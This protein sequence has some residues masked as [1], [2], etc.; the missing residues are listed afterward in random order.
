M[1]F[2]KALRRRQLPTKPLGHAEPDS[3][4]NTGNPLMDTSRKRGEGGI[5]EIQSPQWPAEIILE[6]SWKAVRLTTQGPFVQ[7]VVPDFSFAPVR[8]YDFE[9]TKAQ[10]LAHGAC[11]GFEL[12]L[13]RP[14][15]IGLEPLALDAKSGEVLWRHSFL[16]QAVGPSLV[17]RRQPLGTGD[18]L[19]TPPK[20]PE[21]ANINV[22]G[23]FAYG[24]F[25]KSGTRLQDCEQLFAH[26][27]QSGDCTQIDLK[28][29]SELLKKKVAP[30]DGGRMGRAHVMYL[31]EFA[32]R[33]TWS[34]MQ[35]IA[36]GCIQVS[37]TCEGQTQSYQSVHVVE[38]NPAM[39]QFTVRFIPKT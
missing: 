5:V 2:E 9:A 35:A 29:Y 28:R 20:K 33:Q 17:L 30:P 18:W 7:S 26:I 31:D 12:I 34:V 25:A 23:L 11:A 19:V 13:Q 14:V 6:L 3:P 32:P 39:D 1:Q 22:L 27:T 21:L 10:H 36:F 24:G 4:I 38:E 15:S 16:K 37:L 8:L